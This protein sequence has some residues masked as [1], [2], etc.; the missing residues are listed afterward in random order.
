[1]Y[2]GP[3]GFRQNSLLVSVEISR[4]KVLESLNQVRIEAELFQ[5]RAC[6]PPTH[7]Q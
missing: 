1:L 2:E 4:L 7:T 6:V 5:Q 3:G